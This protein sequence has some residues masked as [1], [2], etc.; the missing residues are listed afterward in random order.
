MSIYRNVKSFL[1]EANGELPIKKPTKALFDVPKNKE[2]I[3]LCLSLIDEEIQ[4]LEDAI[5]NK[6][7]FEMQDAIVDAQW[8]L[9]NLPYYLSID[10]EKM[11]HAVSLSNFSKFC[12]D[13]ENAK[14]TVEMYSNGTH[15]DK[16]GDSCR[17]NPESTHPHYRLGSCAA[18][19]H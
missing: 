5:K 11:E 18:M 14:K 4:E 17:W 8:V 16:Q 2:K 1:T 15:P 3:N 12:R 10:I 6:D 7:V 9:N 19:R 13:E